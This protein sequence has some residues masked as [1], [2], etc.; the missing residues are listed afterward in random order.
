MLP[1][2]LWTAERPGGP[3][4][5]AVELDSFSSSCLFS[6]VVFRLI[7]KMNRRC[8]GL[9]SLIRMQAKTKSSCSCPTAACCL[10]AIVFVLFLLLVFHLLCGCLWMEAKRCMRLPLFFSFLFLFLVASA[11]SVV[12][13]LLFAV[14]LWYIF[15]SLLICLLVPLL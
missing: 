14:F 9:F 7:A 4:V 2:D 3:G 13:P 8:L 15:L 1:A 6:L 5:C 10:L 11:F 12:S